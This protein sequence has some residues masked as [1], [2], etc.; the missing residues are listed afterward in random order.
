TGKVLKIFK[1]HTGPVTSVAVV[2]GS[3]TG[4]EEFLIT[5]S[6]DKT[7]KKWDIE[8][9]EC[10]QTFTGHTDFVKCLLVYK[11]FLFTGSS[12][13]TIR[14][15]DLSTGKELQVFKGHTRGIECLILHPYGD[16]SN[17]GRFIISASSDTT[18]KMWDTVT[19]QATRTFAGHQTSVYGLLLVE[20]SLWSTS[21]DNTAKRWDLETG[22]S[23]CSLEHSDFVKCIQISGGYAFTGSRDENI[24]VWD[25][26]KEKCVGI[27]E[28]H[29]GEVSCMQL[30]GTTLYTASL[31]CTIRSWSVKE[32]DL[33]EIGKAPAIT[34]EAVAPTT[35]IST[36]A[37]TTG[38]KKKGA[39]DKAAGITAAVQS[40]ELTED[41]ERE[42]AELMGDDDL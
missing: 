39:D 27:I 12:D 35:T 18:I 21:A 7:A 24:S 6:W 38:K 23:D 4:K 34:D 10:V 25:I 9:K 8:T 30:V 20:G 3:S 1:G 14:Q 15:W 37:S 33:L 28:G 19:G 11:S 29:F 41:E 16:E 31:D 26:A 5:G 17:P 42:L 40:L 13:K 32:N 36:A 2:Y 22:Q